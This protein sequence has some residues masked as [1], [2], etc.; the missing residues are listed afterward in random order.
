ML[1]WHSKLIHAVLLSGVS[2][3][4]HAQSIELQ[5]ISDFT[6]RESGAVPY[7]IEIAGNRNA[8]AIN[9][10]NPA[11]RNQF[12]RAEHEFL[13]PDG[14]YD[15]TI[16]AL[17]EIDGDGTYRLLVNGIVQG[18]SVNTPVA[19]D[20][21]IIEH[22]FEG[23]ALSAPVTIAVESMAVSNNQIPEGD[24]FAFARGRWRAVTLEVPTADEPDNAEAVDLGMALSTLNELAEQGS[25]IPIIASIINNSQST[26]ATGAFVE[27]ALPNGVE[28]HSSESCSA[29]QQGARC[30]LPELAPG[31]I[32]NTSFQAS[33]ETAGWLSVSATL[34]SDQSDSNLQDNVRNVAFQAQPEPEQTMIIDPGAADSDNEPDNEAE[35][36]VTSDNADEDNA[37]ITE[38]LDTDQFAGTKDDS[39]SGA[40]GIPATFAMLIALLLRV[41]RKK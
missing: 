2:L 24:G 21:T 18:E 34:A 9:A 15:I 7:Y 3:G 5:A 16:H 31:G 22:E 33:I 36:S 28:F 30:D 26:T 23:I 25:Q 6:N 35:D 20:Y 8:L 29:I 1:G 12:A 19:V 14:I 37:S 38:S 4:A 40:L 10:A 27:F 39:V 13:G 17:G 32:V 41:R 11:F